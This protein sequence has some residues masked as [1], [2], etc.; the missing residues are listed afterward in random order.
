[1]LIKKI[2]KRL[3][4]IIQKLLYTGKLYKITNK[5]KIYHPRIVTNI[6]GGLGSQMWQFAFGYATANKA[7][8]P[9]SLHTDFYNWGCDCNGVKNRQFLLFDVFPAIRAVYSDCIEKSDEYRNIF[10]DRSKRTTYE[11]YPEIGK[12][13]KPI[14]LS[15]YYANVKYIHEYR[16]KLR[17]FF[18]FDVQLDLYEKDI[19]NQINKTNSCFVHIRKGDFVGLS[20]DI[21]TKLYY[22][23]AML[24]MLEMVPD[25]V[26]YIFSNDEKYF[27][28]HIRAS[29]HACE[30]RVISV[31]SENTP[32]VDL[33][34]MSICKHA[35][36]ANSGFSWMAA[37]LNSQSGH[38]IMPDI[39]D[40]KPENKEKSKMA[41]YVPGWHQ[42]P[43]E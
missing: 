24:K 33:Y 32:Q 38:V 20:R 10:T 29:L 16:E 9:L 39:W 1:M 30:C 4:P 41:F 28:K 26:F 37:Y 15:Q 31:R 43:V 21:C 36:I 22:V 2:K 18:A 6:D 3:Y 34:L 19:E 12:L 7:N 11:F 40:S 23:R 5:L 27:E 35:I 17:A 25:V 8:L 13:H 42:L 14:F